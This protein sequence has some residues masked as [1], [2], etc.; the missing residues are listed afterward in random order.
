MTAAVDV[1]I[2]G[3]GPA[4]ISAALWCHRLNLDYRLFEQHARIGGQL[5]EIRNR[6]VDYPGILVNNGAELARVFERHLEA[7]NV[8]LSTDAAVSSVS[9][10]DRVL[11]LQ[12]GN[13]VTFRRLILATGAHPRRLGVAGEDNL[14]SQGRIPSTSDDGNRF[15]GQPV[16]VVG[17]GDRAIEGA[18]NLANIGAHVTLIHR[19][20]TF[21]ART[22]FQH[23]LLQHPRIQVMLDT[24]VTAIHGDNAPHRVDTRNA[25]GTV[26]AVRA[27]AV[28]VRIG[29]SP[30]NELVRAQVDT[31]EEGFIRVN[32]QQSTSERDVYAI[33]DVCTPPYFSSVSTATG[34]A[35]VAVKHISA[36]S[37]P[38]L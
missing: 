18:I 26:T 23:T 13:R 9:L 29:V 17:G 35:V 12:T 8:S 37:H 22:D 20:R 21:R 3:A 10:V 14:Y 33:G 30:R 27:T 32:A 11:T 16:V 31:S 7:M 25:N 5:Y 28:F 19:S 4:G 38:S 24:T 15:K 36:T 34:Q 1:V 2:I 6:V